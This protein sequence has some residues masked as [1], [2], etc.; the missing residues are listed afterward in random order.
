MDGMARESRIEDLVHRLR[1][2]KV[3][4][5]ICVDGVYSIM[6]FEDWIST[7]YNRDGADW[8]TAGMLLATDSAI[9]A[10]AIRIVDHQPLT[11][12][13]GCHFKK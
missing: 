12:A 2:L 11:L 1:H 7:L 6:R 13:D 4:E 8:G 5:E 3:Y 9:R 10:L